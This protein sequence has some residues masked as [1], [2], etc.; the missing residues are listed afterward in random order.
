M[1]TESPATPQQTGDGSNEAARP[2]P[3][4]APA[5]RTGAKVSE[6]TSATAGIPVA[7]NGTIML[8]RMGDLGEM[9]A[10]AGS[11]QLHPMRG[12]DPDYTD[13][14]DYIVRITHR[15]WEEKDIGLIYDTYS[16][17]VSVWRTD[18]LTKGREAVVASTV[19]AIAGSPAP[20]IFV[21]EVI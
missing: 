16:H 8:H 18:G 13:I 21:D 7:P 11:G 4:R 6:P 5:A 9:Y 12:F 17:N 15:I 10:R 19:R 1:S 2:A 3:A 20:R 14:V